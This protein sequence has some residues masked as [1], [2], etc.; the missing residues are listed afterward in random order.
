MTPRDRVLAALDHEEPDRIPLD[1]GGG[2]STFNIDVYRDVLRHLGL[3]E[4]IMCISQ[5]VALPSEPVLKRFQIDTR[6]LY[7]SIKAINPNPPPEEVDAWGVRRKLLGYYYEIAPGGHPLAK[8]KGAEELRDYPW[9]KPAQLIGAS[10]SASG[11][12]RSGTPAEQIVEDMVR[13]GKALAERDYA[14]VFPY[15]PIG[16]S[17]AYSMWLRGF[18]AFFGDLVLRPKIA[19]GIMQ[20]VT[21]LLVKTIQDYVRPLRDYVDIVFFGDDLGTQVGPM[22]S[23]HMYR[24]HVKPHHRRIVEAFRNATRAK[25][26]LH[27]DGTV[28]PFIDDIAEI[29]VTGINPVQVSAKDMNTKDLKAR[30]GDKI[31]FWGAIDTQSVLPF[32]T[33]QK[34]RAEVR[35]RIDDLGVRGGYV[36]TS[37]HNMIPPTPARNVVAMFD[38]GIR[39]GSEFCSHQSI[40]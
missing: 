28:S 15:G 26:I 12:N 9:P 30:F 34:V 23:P 13:R 1:L 40:G 11:G 33:E 38:E 3:S 6:Y 39:Y 25:V 7:P 4:E 18:Q 17:F 22:I 20:K 36:L 31:A 2:E 14:V 21:E 35:R 16:G 10:F 8:V 37:V 5:G 32:G 27:T 19:D 24:K 29:G